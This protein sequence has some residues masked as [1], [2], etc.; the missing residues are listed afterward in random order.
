MSPSLHLPPTTLACLMVRCPVSPFHK[1]SS[2]Q[3][4]YHSTQYTSSSPTNTGRSIDPSLAGV[5]VGT[6]VTGAAQR[7]KAQAAQGLSS[8]SWQCSS[9]EWGSLQGKGPQR[10]TGTVFLSIVT[11]GATQISLASL[12]D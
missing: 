6:L 10:A 3:Q 11:H 7:A 9:E 4:C 12:L 2:R 1:H 8:K 5:K